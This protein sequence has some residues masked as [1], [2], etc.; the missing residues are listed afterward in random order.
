VT[1]NTEH[2][3]SLCVPRDIVITLAPR[4]H[5]AYLWLPYQEAAERCFSPSNRTAVLQLPARLAQQSSAE[6]SPKP[7]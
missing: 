4:E 3:F 2:W 7:L 5:I 6:Q 1:R